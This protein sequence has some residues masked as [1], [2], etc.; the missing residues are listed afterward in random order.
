MPRIWCHPFWWQRHHLWWKM[1]QCTLWDQG[2]SAVSQANVGCARDSSAYPLVH[3]DLRQGAGALVQGLSGCP[4][5]DD[6][7]WIPWGRTVANCRSMDRCHLFIQSRVAAISPFHLDRDRRLMLLKDR[8]ASRLRSLHLSVPLRVERECGPIPIHGLFNFL[9]HHV[10]SHFLDCTGQLAG[11]L[12][13][14]LPA[15]DTKLFW[16]V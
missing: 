16:D 4:G 8:D 3:G 9:L 7:Q 1:E 14:D 11:P 15:H 13:T 2:R 6:D 5:Q 10:W 12:C